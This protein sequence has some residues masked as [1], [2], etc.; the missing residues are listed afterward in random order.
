M[1]KVVYFQFKDQGFSNFMGA[2]VCAQQ[3]YVD[4]IFSYR[5]LRIGA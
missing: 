4:E 2:I 5:I 1:V 3:W